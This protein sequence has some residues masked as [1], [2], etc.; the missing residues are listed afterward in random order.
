MLLV[1]FEDGTESVIG[2]TS[3]GNVSLT[4]TVG[5]DGDWMVVGVDVLEVDDRDVFKDFIVEISS[6]S[7]NPSGVFRRDNSSYN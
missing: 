3:D 6:R 7:S 2:N 4:T 1:E 5:W